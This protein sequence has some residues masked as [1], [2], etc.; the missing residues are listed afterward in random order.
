M[1]LPTLLVK[2]NLVPTLDKD[3]KNYNQS[4]QILNNYI[5]IDYVV[6]WIKDRY[7]GIGR[8]DNDTPTIFDRLLIL[9]SKTGSGKSS[10]VPPVLYKTFIYGTDNER[11]KPAVVCTQPRV[12]TAKEL[13]IEAA[14]KSFYVPLTLGENIGYQTGSLVEKGKYGITYCTIGI[15]LQ[16]LRMRDD[17]LILKKYRF[18]VL[19]EIHERSTDMDQVFYLLKSFMERVL[20]DPRAPFIILT[21]ATFDPIVYAKFFGVYQ[22]T[23]KQIEDKL[24]GQTNIIDVEGFAYPV[25]FHWLDHT[26]TNYA[27]DMA[28]IVLKIHSDSK[29]DDLKS[30]DILIFVPGAMNM[31]TIISALKKQGGIPD[32][33]LVLK[34]ESTAVESR[35]RD[36]VYTM[37]AYNKLPPGIKRRL[38]IST[39]VAETGLTIES[40][41][42]VLDFGYNKAVEFNPECCISELLEKPAPKSRI[43]QRKGRAGRKNPGEFFPIYAEE[44]YNSLPDIQLPSIL[45]SD[46]TDML[47]NI[48]AIN[49][50]FNIKDHI[51]NKM[52]EVVSPQCLCVAIS[53]LTFT[54]LIEPATKTDFKITDL[55]NIA[56][57]FAKIRAECTRMILNAYA[58][59]PPMPQLKNNEIVYITPKVAVIDLITIAAIIENKNELMRN[60]KIDKLNTL[61][62]KGTPEWFCKD[63]DLPK[64]WDLC[65]DELIIYLFVFNSVINALLTGENPHEWAE[66]NNLNINTFS[67]IA[68]TRNSIIDNMI[69]IGLDINHNIKY[70]IINNE[71]TTDEFIQGAKRA[72]QSGFVFN[73]MKILDDNTRPRY[74]HEHLNSRAEGVNSFKLKL[75]D[76]I[77]DYVR[78]KQIYPDSVIPIKIGM[79]QMH[80]PTGFSE[81][82]PVIKMIS[83]RVPNSF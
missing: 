61:L 9:R 38:I 43:M 17:E 39:N 50:E 81:M 12:V 3:D 80:N 11:K 56:T 53:K 20:P 57:K 69:N 10:T 46:F 27:V 6:K 26:S 28:K 44:T 75:E 68:Q 79:L 51:I 74:I 67:S 36:Y 59:Y 34:L 62:K 83:V 2:G 5:P 30:C 52:L 33:L 23:P 45:E 41:K 58:N 19:D 54:G 78:T 21:S 55:G 82:L 49:Q 71:N 73:T 37:A 16:Q 65:E 66:S 42:Y 22:D 48:A 31:D 70:S 76:P 24:Y 77:M 4:L 1:P 15:L 40:L 32:D 29:D 60:M 72:I 18:I 13:A 8:P 47:M 25:K 63:A 64:V 14:E 35:S 7:P